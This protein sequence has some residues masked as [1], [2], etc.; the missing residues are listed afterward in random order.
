MEV[1]NYNQRPVERVVGKTGVRFRWLSKE[2]KTTDYAMCLF[3]IEPGAI[4]NPH[5]H[6]CAQQIFVLSGRGVALGDRSRIPLGA[7][8]VVYVPPLEHHRFRNN[9][10]CVLSMLTVIS[11]PNLVDTNENPSP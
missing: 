5:V 9:G 1:E 3:E 6:A 2:S 10:A 11:V 8:D 4:T 7:G